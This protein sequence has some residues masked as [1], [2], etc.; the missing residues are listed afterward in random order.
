[1]DVNT[2][3]ELVDYLM[4]QPRDRLVVMAKDVEGNGY[5]PLADAV[6]A[7]YEAESTW[8]GEVYL[9]PEELAAKADPDDWTEAPDDAVRVVL[10]GPVN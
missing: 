4:T 6:E 8:A 3:G 1:M 2:V 7:M 5:S 10:L 9:T